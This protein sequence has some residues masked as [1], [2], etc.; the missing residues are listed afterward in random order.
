MW[1]VSLYLWSP[2]DFFCPSQHLIFNNFVLFAVRLR[3][4][5]TLVTFLLIVCCFRHQAPNDYIYVMLAI[6]MKARSLIILSKIYKCMS[7]GFWLLK[8]EMDADGAAVAMVCI[9]DQRIMLDFIG[10]PK[11]KKIDR[12]WPVAC[13][14]F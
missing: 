14:D 4:V 1:F 8:F 3:S 7:F 6:E 13:L 11:Q 10:E 12:H 2:L 5:K 9:H